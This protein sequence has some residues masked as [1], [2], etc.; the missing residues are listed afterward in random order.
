MPALLMLTSNLPRWTGDS[1]TPFVLH[2]A[3]D[4]LELGWSV[5]VLAPHAAGAAVTEDLGGVRVHRF[6][7]ARD[8]ERQL[9]GYGGGALMNIRRSRRAA[10]QVPVLV[11]AELVAAARLLRRGRF[12][13]VQSHWLLPQGAVAGIATLGTGVPHVATVHGSD[14]LGLDSPPLRS[15][16][17]GVLAR[18]QAVTVNSSA[19]EAAVRRLAAPGLAIHRVPMGISVASSL[20]SPPARTD[21][22]PT[23]GYVGRLVG[24]KGVADLVTAVGLLRD[25]GHSRIRC[26]IAGVGPEE[27]ALR[28]QLR[29]LG[30]ADA[31]ELLGWVD[32][33]EVP[34]LLAT[35]D[36]AVY[37][38]RIE[39]DGTT[40]GQGLSV[41]E[42]MAAARPVVATRVGGIPDSIS[43]GV[44][45]LLVPERSPERLAAAISSLLDDPATA[46]RI[47]AAARDRA[48]GTFS[49]AASA[50][51]FDTILTDVAEHRSRR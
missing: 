21:R 28:E 5:E 13:V 7:Y 29:R 50:R 38:S 9:V 10:L 8:P 35:L 27:A 6:R 17:R 40:E 3:Q 51:R 16:K 12:D 26:V 18:T 25:R 2:L 37:P 42:A 20:P 11:A 39:A 33:A 43:D 22:R 1:T 24:W 34:R 46:S 48:V 49:R 32:H 41:L 4:L 15:V 44:E 36:V 23:V 30:L 47:G 19:T 14:V 45:G 31:V